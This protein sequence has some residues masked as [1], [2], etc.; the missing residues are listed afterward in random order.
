VNR[1]VALSR[2]W[3]LAVAASAACA[4][5]GVW[6]WKT[7]RARRRKSPDEIER[8]RRLRVNACG[9]IIPGTIVE[10]ADSMPEGAPG[11]ILVY[12]Y[13]VAGVTYAVAQDVSSLP[14]VAAAAPMLPGQTTSVKYDP[15]QPTN[16]I[17]ACESWCGIPDLAAYREALRAR[18]EEAGEK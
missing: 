18:Q 7:V 13:E 1:I 11:T 8:L 17:L 6:V 14:K 3:G 15:R 5:A 4:L 9:R 10:L 12:E 2:D 16:S